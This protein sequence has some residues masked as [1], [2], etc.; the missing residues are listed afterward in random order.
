MIEDARH[1]FTDAY[2]R[3]QD[4]LI[5][6]SH[7]R[8]VTRTSVPLGREAAFQHAMN[9]AQNHPQ[10]VSMFQ[11][12][13]LS[14]N[15]EMQNIFANKAADVFAENVITAI[16]AASLL[17]IYATLDSVLSDH[18]HCSALIACHD[19]KSVIVNDK[20]TAEQFAGLS[21]DELARKVHKCRLNLK[22]RSGL[23]AKAEALCKICNPSVDLMSK[24]GIIYDSKRLYQLTQ[25]RN[26]IAHGDGLRK[27]IPDFEDE[28]R[29]LI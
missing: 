19:W 22:E 24:E 11:N 29:F 23:S 14:Q 20:F 16:N 7:F 3:W 4:G 9:I 13:N 25:A 5:V 18:L 26:E 8:Q 27:P 17:F 12:Q 2:F 28:L 21:D 6:A 1:I 10:M 15:A